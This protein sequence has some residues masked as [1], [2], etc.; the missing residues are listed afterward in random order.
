VWRWDI[1]AYLFAGGLA[2]GTS[3][4]AAAGQLTGR[5]RLRRT[6]RWGAL[7]AVG[8]SAYF[9]IHDLGR[10]ERFHHM[11]RVAKPTSPMSMGTW[12]LSAFGPAAGI[13]AVAELAPWLPRSGPLGLVRRVLPSVGNAAGL[14]AGSIAPALATYTG[15]LLA[16]TAVPAWHD[17][18][19]HLPYVFAAGAMASAAGVTMLVEPNAAHHAPVRRLVLAAAVTE[20]LSGRRLD[21][22]GFTGEPYHQGRAGWLLRGGRALLVV[23]LGGA[24]LGRRSPAL[25]AAAGAALLAS[26]AAVRFGI[27]EAGLASARDPRY[28]VVP[29]R[30]RRDRRA[31]GDPTSA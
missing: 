11:L 27:F 13:A 23:G 28:T 7:G 9:L 18:H 17:A 12:I 16:D 22:M 30:E 20:F 15:V 2:A 6:G 1:P 25:T 10:P 19:P 14:A 24:L 31:A 5:P 26:S 3:M 4:I 29:Q 21:R 8:A